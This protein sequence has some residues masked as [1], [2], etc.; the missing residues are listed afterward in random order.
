MKYKLSDYLL[1]FSCVFAGL[2]LYFVFYLVP[3]DKVVETIGFVIFSMLYILLIF[4]LPMITFYYWRE[5]RYSFKSKEFLS[6]VF[7]TLPWTLT[8]FLLLVRYVI[9]FVV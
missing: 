3:N 6:L 1:L 2:F 5:N 9:E 8:I 4:L 7:S